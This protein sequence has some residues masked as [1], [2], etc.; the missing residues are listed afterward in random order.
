MYFKFHDD[1]F[2]SYKSANILLKLTFTN[3]FSIIEHV[4][5]RALRNADEMRL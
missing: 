2:S 3:T 5:Q 4:E 1:R